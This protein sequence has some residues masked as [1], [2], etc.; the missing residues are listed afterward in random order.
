MKVALSM[1]IRP[2]LAIA[3][4]ACAAQGEELNFDRAIAP[5]VKQFCQDCHNAEEHEGDF[6]LDGIR[7]ISEVAADV[8]R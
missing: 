6:R 5:L 2:A 1:V 4:I 3:V 8:N 7:P